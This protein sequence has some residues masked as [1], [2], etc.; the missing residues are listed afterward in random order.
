MHTHTR[1]YSHIHINNF[2]D[3]GVYLNVLDA[4]IDGDRLPSTIVIINK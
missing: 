3:Q 4:C 2:I 1:T